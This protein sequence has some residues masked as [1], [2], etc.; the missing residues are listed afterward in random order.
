M[1]GLLVPLFLR[2][3]VSQRLSKALAI[4]TVILGVCSPPARG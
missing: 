1:I 4:L 2:L 3:G